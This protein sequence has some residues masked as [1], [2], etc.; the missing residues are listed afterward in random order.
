MPPNKTTV[1]IVDDSAT[2]RSLVSRILDE[3]PEIEVV[4]TAT[5]PYD[6]KD[7]IINLDPDVVTLDI[8]MPRMD[9]IT[10]LKLIMERRPRP[11]IMMSSLTGRGA[12][13]AMEALQAGAVDVIDKPGGPHTVGE[14]GPKLLHAVKAAGAAKNRLHLR[15]S[16]PSR[17]PFV[18]KQK[19]FQAR[20]LMLLGAS[21]GGTEALK[22]VLTALPPDIPPICMVQHI[23]ALF[24]TAFAERLNTLCPFEVREAKEGDIAK[25]GLALLAPG[26]Y[27]MVLRWQVKH[28]VVSVRKGPMVWHQRPAV[29]VMFESVAPTADKHVVAAV[30]TGMGRDGGE[31]MLK[32]KQKGARTFA[33]TEETCVVYGMPK[34]CHELGAAERMVPLDHMAQ[35]L[36]S[37]LPD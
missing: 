7:K 3:D 15:S 32:L 21:T 28:Y 2:V 33:Q 19:H 18:R 6:A 27:H 4:G 1:L 34:T 29:D 26:D 20:D 36:M 25:P 8:E 16:R 22:T 13:I 37:A 23:P 12:G 31:G 5:D 14:A 10:F 30:L 11:V 9:G 24:S 17:A 35:V